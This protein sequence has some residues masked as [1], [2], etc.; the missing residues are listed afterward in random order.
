MEQAD[1]AQLDRP[2][3]DRASSSQDASEAQVR[4]MLARLRPSP[5]LLGGGC[6][7]IAGDPREPGAEACEAPRVQG[8]PYCQAHCLRAYAGLQQVSA[9]TMRFA[10]AAHSASNVEPPDERDRSRGEP[11]EVAWPGR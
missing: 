5:F 6:R 1:T 10:V 7:W 8:R 9:A 2:A 4:A 3:V 11:G